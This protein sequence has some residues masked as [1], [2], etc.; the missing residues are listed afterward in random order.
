MERRNDKKEEKIHEKD[1]KEDYEIKH[2][3]GKKTKH[4][5]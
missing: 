5:I 1:E 3:K 2:I 4:K